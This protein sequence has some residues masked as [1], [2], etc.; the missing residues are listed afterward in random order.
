MLQ[1]DLETNETEDVEEAVNFR[2]WVLELFRNNSKAKMG[3]KWET[4]KEELE[5]TIR[6]QH[7]INKKII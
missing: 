5:K 4:G 6:K 7:E 1:F 3:K 2:F